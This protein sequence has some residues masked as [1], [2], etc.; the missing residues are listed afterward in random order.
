MAPKKPTRNSATTSRKQQHV[1]LV[2]DK[3]VRF[4]SKTTG[5]ERFSFIHNALPEIAFSEITPSVEFLGKPLRIPLIISSMTGG[6]K[7]AREINRGLASVCADYGIA[8]GVGSERQ[9]LED[10]RFHETFSVV[11]EVSTEIPVIA[12]VGAAQVGRMR[13]VDDARLLIDLVHADALAIHLNPLQELLQPEGEPDFRGVLRGIEMLAAA[14]PVPVIVKEIG[15]GISQNVAR[16]LLGAGVRY[17]DVAGAGGTSWAGVEAL[18]SKKKEFAGRF[19]DWGIPTADAIRQVASLRNAGS[20][21]TLISSGGITSGRDIA[22]SIALGADLAA[23]AR[24]V[25][26]AL[27]RGGTAAVRDLLADWEEE[28]RAIMFLAGARTIRE[29]QSV[30]LQEEHQ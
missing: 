21:F 16:R 4:K 18:R 10:R 13:S 19:W 7:G 24:P 23:S 11:R 30:P 27:T 20:A 9:A 25:L 12:N 14:L 22:V 17:I 3:D 2:L 1:A 29:L 26:Q 28:L 15:A 8:M 5:L 6:Y